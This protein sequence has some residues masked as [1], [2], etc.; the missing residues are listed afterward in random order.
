MTLDELL[1]NVLLDID[2]EKSDLIIVNKLKKFIN[3]GYRELA[4][5]EELSKTKDITLINGKC[6]LPFDC[7]KVLHALVD[8]KQVEYKVLGRYIYSDNDYLTLFYNYI[9]DLLENKDDEFETN[10]NNSEFISLYAKYLYYFSE[11][12]TEESSIFKMEYEKYKIE[13]NKPS[14]EKIIDVYGV[15]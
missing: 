9:P 6:K 5:R 8:G 14:I 1:E 2:E 4:K 12:L 13:K 3:R 11:S 10:E 15:V 7:S